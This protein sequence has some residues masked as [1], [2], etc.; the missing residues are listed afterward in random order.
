MDPKKKHV[1]VFEDCCQLASD[2]AAFLSS[3]TTGDESWIYGYDPETKPQSSQQKKTIVKSTHIIY[4]DII[5]KEF[6]LAGQG[7]SSAY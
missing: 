1:I 6:I 2:D 7:V 4:F 5:H 3:V